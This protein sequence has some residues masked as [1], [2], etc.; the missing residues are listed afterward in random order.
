MRP[1]TL[2]ARIG[3]ILAAIATPLACS[4]QDGPLKYREGTHYVQVR[5]PEA[6]TT[7]EGKVQVA[8]V[9]WYGCSH[10]YRFDPT[11]EHWLE[12]LPEHIEFVRIPTALGRPQNL[13]HSRAYYTAEV[14]GVLPDVHDKIFKAIHVQKK[15]LLTEAQIAEVFADAGVDKDKFSQTFNSF[16][17]DSRVKRA[18]ALVRQWG[19]PSVPTVV[20]DGTWQTNGRYAGSNKDALDVAEFLAAKA[21]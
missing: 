14:L 17:V 2:F 7:S 12:D 6:P 9:F 1:R 11:V 4:A 5:N 8:E 15:S 18:E 19:I 20:V 21:Q 13:M 16:G 10:C 3:L